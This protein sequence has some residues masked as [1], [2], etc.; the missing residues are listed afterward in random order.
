MKDYRSLPHL[1]RQPGFRE[2]PGCHLP[3]KGE[4][5]RERT[6][7]PS[8]SGEGG[9]GLKGPMTDE[10]SPQQ[11]IVVTISLPR[12]THNVSAAFV[13]SPSALSILPS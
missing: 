9:I 7:Q 13:Y 6:F 4:G 1:I 12:Q 10:V 8:P 5:L 2:T 3:L 11:A